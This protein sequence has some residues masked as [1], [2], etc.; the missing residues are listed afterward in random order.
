MGFEV[1]SDGLHEPAI[2][3]G[4]IE[5]KQEISAW[6]ESGFEFFDEPLD[7]GCVCHSEDI[8]ECEVDISI[9]FEGMEWTGMDGV[10]RDVQ[11]L[12]L[13]LDRGDECF[14]AFNECEVCIGSDLV[15]L[16]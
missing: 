5:C 8:E 15:V 9:E 13:S 7:V 16:D 1:L 14:P 10:M 2:T 6:C 3:D 4:A 12:E 11:L